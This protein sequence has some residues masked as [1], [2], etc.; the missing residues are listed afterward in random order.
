MAVSSV[1]TVTRCKLQL[2]VSHHSL[3]NLLEWWE[4]RSSEL[5]KELPLHA[6]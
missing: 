6:A 4:L 2:V 5:G 1:Q 3:Q